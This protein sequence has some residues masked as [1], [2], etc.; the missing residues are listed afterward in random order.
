MTSPR[1]RK[2]STT[3]RKPTVRGTSQTQTMINQDYGLALA[4]QHDAPLSLSSRAVF[5]P[6]RY[7]APSPTLVHLPFLF[8]LIES[9]R[10]TSVVQLGLSDGV[11][12]MG[13]CQA[14]DKLGLE[15]VCMGLNLPQDAGGKLPDK[16]HETHASLYSDFSFI[17]TDELG[18]AARHMRSAKID[19]LVIDAAVDEAFMNSLQAHWTDLLS[20]HAVIVLH[21]PEKAFVNP[22]TKAFHENLVQTHATV[23][24]PQS[25]PG[26]DVILFGENQPDRLRHLAQLD[27]G[28]PGYLTARSVFTRL[29]QGIESA[30]SARSKSFALDK[31]K[32][33]IKAMEAQLSDLERDYK[34]EKEKNAAA[35]HSEEAQLNENAM[36]QAQLFDL[37]QALD[38]ARVNS[39]KDEEIEILRKKL[40]KRDD[41]LKDLQDT[42]S[43]EQAKRKSHWTKLEAAEAEKAALKDQVAQAEKD[44]QVMVEKHNQAMAAA[45]EKLKHSQS[46]RLQLWE[47]YE[48]LKLE[49]QALQRAKDTASSGE[50]TSSDV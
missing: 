5:W 9:T 20:D 48:A 6:P 24:F 22:E 35:L 3:S 10:P 33:S 25:Q 27:L 13:L 21:A 12:F 42:L 32:I 46:K 16:L 19:L 47:D 17:L 15:S 36:L 37:Q 50:N 31:A 49:Y 2:T 44:A 18:R 39:A 28:A 43:S 23:S 45:M 40:Q 4:G 30:Q 26:L 11:G 38:A 7:T 14:I 34:A 1:S 41:T 29:G 8:W